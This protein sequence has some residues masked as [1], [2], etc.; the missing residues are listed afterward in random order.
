VV[1]GSNTDIT[2]YVNYLLML[3][4]TQFASHFLLSL[5]R[6]RRA[7]SIQ[8]RMI[9]PAL[10]GI[11]KGKLVITDD[12]DGIEVPGS[13]VKVKKSRASNPLHPDDV[14]I[15][16]TRIFPTKQN[17]QLDRLFNSNGPDPTKQ[18]LEGIKPIPESFKVILKARGVT[19]DTLERCEYNYQRDKWVNLE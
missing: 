2:K 19:T 8:V 9:C 6:Y 7:T 11:A 17:S 13:M 10:F 14:A 12:I 1:G 15:V 16:I 4:R 18:G 5:S 3:S